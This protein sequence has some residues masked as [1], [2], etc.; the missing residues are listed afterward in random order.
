MLLQSGPVGPKVGL[1]SS[2]PA[3]LILVDVSVETDRD[4]NL[5][6]AVWSTSAAVGKMSD[7]VSCSRK[8][9]VLI[10]YGLP[11]QNHGYWSDFS[12][13]LRFRGLSHSVR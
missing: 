3:R 1:T 9:Q 5:N 8:I 4:D 10:R 13:P 12:I 2:W 7:Q 6:P 11:C